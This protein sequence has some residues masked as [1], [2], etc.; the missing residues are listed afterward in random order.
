MEQCFYKRVPVLFARGCIQVC[1]RMSAW[2]MQ[3][4]LLPMVSHYS[5]YVQL[6]VNASVPAIGKK[7]ETA[8][9]HT[10][11]VTNAGFT[12]FL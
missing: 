3:F 5:T 12:C 7:K 4:S 1:T 8:S 2:T 10:L 6:A 9:E 11:S